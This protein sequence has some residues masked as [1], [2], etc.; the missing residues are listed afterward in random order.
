MH[1]G[2]QIEENSD[3]MAHYPD[4]NGDNFTDDDDDEEDF[5]YENDLADT[6]VNIFFSFNFISHY[7]D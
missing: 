1:L 2:Q 3:Q 6:H 4:E 7:L 5:S